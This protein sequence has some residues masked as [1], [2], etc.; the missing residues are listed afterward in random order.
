MSLVRTV[1]NEYN[2]AKENYIKV[3]KRIIKEKLSTVPETLKGYRIEIIKAHNDIVRIIRKHYKQLPSVD[4]TYFSGELKYIGDKT[5]ECFQ[6][7]LLDIRVPAN[8]L[9]LI[10]EPLQDTD[11]GSEDISLELDQVPGASGTQSAN[12]SAFISIPDIE[13]NN[14]TES[15]HGS[16]TKQNQ[17]FNM[18]QQSV[19]DFL[20]LAGNQINQKYSG[21]PLG[22]SS[23]IDAI[24]LLKQLAGN[25]GDFLKQFI[26]S[27]LD[28]KARECVPL[29]PDSIDDI[30]NALKKTI[31]PDSSKV[32]EGRMLSL[33]FDASKTTDYSKQAED[34]AEALQRSLIVEGIPQQKA[35]SM[36]VERTVEMCRQSSRSDTIESV[37]AA[38][39]FVEPKEVV[40][41]FLIETNNQQ[42]R[43][44]DKQVF[45]FQRFNNKNRGNKRQF[46]NR[47]N[48]NF[49]NQNNS[50]SNYRNNRRGRGGNNRFNSRR[51]NRQ[52]YSRSYGQSNSSNTRYVNYAENASGPSQIQWRPENQPQ[53]HIPFEQ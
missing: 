5:N 27:K 6:R 16:R 12:V 24:N 2:V 51:G 17:D 37:L 8:L 52:N 48:N 34:L 49:S 11:T 41:K 46:N 13:D 18:A 28:G 14:R 33:K 40:A 45:A 38:T 39:A 53:P 35:K 21:D 15:I 32:I 47:Q 50:N 22:L 9:N 42:K 20:R 44:K 29:E 3:A 36:A 7:L 23:F 25:H 10:A 30:I 31:K 19:S 26:L 1:R 4:K 43:Q